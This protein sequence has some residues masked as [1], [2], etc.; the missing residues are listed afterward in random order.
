MKRPA[1]PLLADGK[2]IAA[3][4]RQ[5]LLFLHAAAVPHQHPA[6][7]RGVF[8]AHRHEKR[9]SVQEIEGVYLRIGH[10][11][12]ISA[13]EVG[14]LLARAATAQ[15]SPLLPATDAPQPLP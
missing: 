10:T 5:P 2:S 14:S 13:N 11:D 8:C 15:P 9:R 3:A 4:S 6:D 1:A 12:Q 7:F